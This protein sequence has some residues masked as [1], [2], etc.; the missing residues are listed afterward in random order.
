MVESLRELNVPQTEALLRSAQ[1]A[2]RR[3]LVET[4]VAEAALKDR[5][6]AQD[7]IDTRVGQILVALA[8][9]GV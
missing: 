6:S 2:M 1:A 9:K 4:R 5:R 7:V 3:A 8:E